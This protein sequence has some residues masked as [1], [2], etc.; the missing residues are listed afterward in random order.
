MP[1]YES[2]IEY[3]A[4]RLGQFIKYFLCFV[5]GLIAGYGWGAIAL[6]VQI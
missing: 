2:D 4:S 6:G 5:C 1:L 3:E